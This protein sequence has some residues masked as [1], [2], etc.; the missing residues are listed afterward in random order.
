MIPDSP[1]RLGSCPACDTPD[2]YVGLDEKQCVNRQCRHYDEGWATTVNPTTQPLARPEPAR[3]CQSRE[4][5]ALGTR[6][7]GCGYRL[8]AEYV[9]QGNHLCGM[10]ALAPPVVPTP[11]SPSN[12]PK[13]IV[14]WRPRAVNHGYSSI[15]DHIHVPVVIDS[16][17]LRFL[18]HEA[19]QDRLRAV[20]L[21]R[22]D[23]SGESGQ[24]S[25]IADSGNG[26]PVEFV[27][28]ERPL[29]LLQA[30]DTV[31]E[32]VPRMNVEIEISHE[33]R[34]DV[35]VEVEVLWFGRPIPRVREP[36]RRDR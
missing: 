3:T 13:V 25:L 8:S 17:A 4:I 36:G 31:A 14:P 10:C 29:A 30:V 6:C 12:E 21:R 5:L 16:L 18:P 35:P 34:L 1:V 20:R 9:A 27:T 24:H 26:I 28:Q 2:F 19:A 22:V 7:Q 11:A 23:A 15:S 33:T 32:K